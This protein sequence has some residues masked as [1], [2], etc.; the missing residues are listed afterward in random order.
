MTILV[1][2]GTGYVGGAI[3]PALSQRGES[4]RVLARSTCQAEDLK[5]I[6]VEVV[7]RDILD[8]NSLEGALDGCDTLY[9]AAAIYEIWVP[10]KQFVDT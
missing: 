5:N 9:H 1:T 2:G 6:G 8:K 10:D 7:L 3:A 4:V